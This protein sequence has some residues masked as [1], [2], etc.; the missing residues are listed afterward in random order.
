M[1][2]KAKHIKKDGTVCTVSAKAA[3]RIP[4]YER[5]FRC[6][7]KDSLGNECNSI[8]SL[9]KSEINGKE[10]L[11]FRGHDHIIG[12]SNLC[13]RPEV[14]AYIDSIDKF[15]FD[16]FF[17]HLA[18]D[19][20]GPVNPGHDDDGEEDNLFDVDFD[21]KDTLVDINIKHRAPRSVKTLY[22]VLSSLPLDFIVDGKKVADILV[23]EKT[24]ECEYTNLEG[25]KVLTVQRC[26]P[27]K[28]LEKSASQI[29]VRICGVRDTFLVLNIPEKELR[30]RVWNLIYPKKI[31]NTD[32]SEKEA[33]RTSRSLPKILVA[34]RVSHLQEN[35]FSC[36]VLNARMVAKLK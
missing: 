1:A 8:V 25:Y 22:E 6:I 9:V 4:K 17:R 34:G 11:Y 3:A 30:Q 7:G 24:H 28:G 26:N 13:C 23:T 31:S 14:K 20:K 36:D 35:I 21:E 16:D 2:E 12:C 10:V 33:R 5:N 19:R 18:D 29:V 27:P 15:S 32:S